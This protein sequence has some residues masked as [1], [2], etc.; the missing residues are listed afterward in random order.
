MADAKKTLVILDGMAYAFRA[1]YAVPEMTN[2][3]GQATNAVFGFAN[4]LRRAE[5]EFKP[6]ACVVAF[7]SPG[8]SFRDEMLSE[9]KGHR[10][11][12]PEALVSQFPLIEELAPLMGWRLL[13]QS[14]MEADDI[15]ATLCKAGRKAGYQVVL[16]TSDKDIL[17]LVG[18]GVRV[19]RENPKGASLY[20]PEQV[21]ER[22]G[23]GPEQIGDLLGL[24]GDSSD[25]IPGVPGIG[26]KTA[27]KLL[28]EHGT[29]EKV[30]KAAATMKP[31]KLAENPV[32]FAEQARL[33]RRLTELKDDVQL[34]VKVDDL[35]YPGPDFAGLLPWFDRMGLRTLLADYSAKAHSAGVDAGQAV[36]AAKAEAAQAL[37]PA[38]RGAGK[39]KPPKAAA[40]TALKGAT[41]GALRKAGLDPA[42]PC[43]V[44]LAPE[45]LPAGEAPRRLVLAQ[46]GG[47]ALLAIV[48]WEQ[49]REALA[50]LEQPV[51]FQAK[52]LQRALLEAGLE[53]LKGL[54]DVGVAGWLLNSTRVARDLAEAAAL[55]GLTLD[56][57]AAQAELFE[58]DD[59]ELRKG[60]EALAALGGEL[61]KRLKADGMDALYDDLEGP[62]LGLLARME[63][64]GIRIDVGALD[65]LEAEA[66]KEMAS[67]QKKALKAAGR[68][69]N[70]N[71]P[72][73]LAEVLFTDLGL[74]PGK[75]TKT[76]Y[77]TDSDVLEALSEE[78]ELPHLVLE[79]RQLAK[80]SGT[81]LQAL[82][83]LVAA[84]GR[85]HSTWNQT[86]TAT[87]RLSSLD[88]NLQNIPVR[89]ELGKRIRHAFVAGKRGDLIL[90]ADYSQIELRVLAHY[91]G[92]PVLKQAFIEGRDIHTET[93]ARMHH[94]KAAEVTSE[95]RSRAKV[96]NFGV[97]YGMGAFRISREF[98]VPLRE[99]K[100]FLDDYFGQFPRVREFLEGCKQ[101]TRDS[102]YACTLLKRRRPIPEINS[103]N[104]VLRE[105]GERIAT[106][107]PIQGTAA[108]LLKLAMLAVEALLKKRQ[109]RTRLM[110]TVHDEL[111]FEL[112]K[113][114]AESLPPLI[115]KAMEG[116]M[117][118]DVPVR[119]EM[120]Q[121][122]SWADA[123]G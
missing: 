111:V 94:V 42:R 65:G 90:A 4:A 29:M 6:T 8:G 119:V 100:S 55:L 10:D 53:P 79:H 64:D 3:Q 23:V 54:L 110:L 48:S 25:N 88:P 68:E 13:K 89:T 21:R 73:Q 118:L 39:A 45:L 52:P 77:S 115:Q 75:K 120:G 86:G 117:K 122:R 93:A 44:A 11:A 106:N 47:A 108:D 61:R 91:C 123:K 85:V 34:G 56:L 46:A 16:L 67:L 12:P 95:M 101:S 62:L 102:G 43:G 5:R 113:E 81:Y 18:D 72:S 71:S 22:Y 51:L 97:L 83:R 116:A 20:G 1:F 28:V 30:L 69:F 14:R 15:M 84:D 63:K 50:L 78:H 41:A 70:L 24:M 105:Q 76:G 103:A 112:A 87:G 37:A 109:A 114:E 121:G 104:R 33:S 74:K 7:D 49:L 40:L 19:Y 59:A 2:A 82:P 57:P 58:P 32:A 107:L 80:L 26:E 35:A 60:A 9:Y 31:G 36:A 27:A 92:D 99:A 66:Q 98:G 38:G 96:I 17:Q